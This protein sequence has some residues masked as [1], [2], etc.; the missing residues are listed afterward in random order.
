MSISLVIFAFLL[1][2]AAGIAIGWF[3]MRPRVR[4]AEERRADAE[5]LL[6]EQRADFTNLQSSFKGLSADVLREAREDFIKQAEPAIAQHVAPLKDAL[7]RYDVALR[8]IEQKRGQAYGGLSR[9][10]ELLQGFAQQLKDETG[11]LKNALK[12][13]S[14]RGRWGEVTL[15]RVA[16]LSG[17]SAHCDFDE[18][19]S[20]EGDSGRL[21]PDMIVH[22][23]G[24]K[25]V[26]VDAK[27]PLDGYL[28]ATEA[29]SEPDR[30]RYLGEHA[31]AVRERMRELSLKGY[32]EQFESSTDLV[33]MFLPGESF[34]AAALEIDRALLE[35]GMRAKVLIA[36]PSTLVALL[37]SFAMGWQQEKLAENAK[38]ISEAGKELFDRVIKFAGYFNK[39]GKNLRQAVEAFNDGVGSFERMLVPGARRLKE[40]GA[41]KT[42]DAEPPTVESIEIV[43]RQ[44]APTEVQV[45]N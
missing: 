6:N 41:S 34:A 31:R 7:S 15:R 28:R 2:F 24:G 37:R 4:L 16:E 17:M 27:T 1:S 18:Q 44:I 12:S 35:D 32:W 9:Q 42:P 33:V 13:S 8:D 10:L 23:P 22:I 19:A 43:P 5:R 11:S 36:T 20:A 39:A 25:N 26:V 45:E 30:L 21:R 38:E 3:L 40:L 29:T 14:A